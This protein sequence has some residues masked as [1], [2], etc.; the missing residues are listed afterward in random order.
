VAAREPK[1]RE[2][3]AQKR[4]APAA[5]RR[6]QDNATVEIRKADLQELL[7][8][9]RSARDGETSVRL[10]AQ[11][12]GVMGDVAKAFN[13]LAERRESLTA[14]LSRVSGVIGREG[15]M[16]ERARMK[17][18]KGTWAESISSVN[19][20]IDDLVRPTIEVSRVLD[21]VAEGD[22]SQKMSLKIE[23]QPV[24][25]EFLRIGTT[26]NTM[27]DQLSSFAS[28]VTRVAREVGTEGIL[29]GQARV[30]DVSGIWRDLTDNVNFMAN[31][32]TTQ[33]RNIAEVTTAVANGDLS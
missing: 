7:D 1:T 26:V 33:V 16:T 18:A 5:N 22:L 23:G 9:L 3:R 12:S 14:E 28:E 27:L 20:M 10:P 32:L 31:N 11:K 8:A 29:G 25:G 4:S 6:A 15:R 24:R 2:R 21:A 19:S 13:S 30:K 17:N